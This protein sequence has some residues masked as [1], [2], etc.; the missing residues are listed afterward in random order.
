MANKNH[1]MHQVCSHGWSAF[2]ACVRVLIP[3]S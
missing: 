1:D 3:E 2:T